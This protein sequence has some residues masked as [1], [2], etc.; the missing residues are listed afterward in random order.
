MGQQ[1]MCSWYG[2]DILHE[3]W[4]WE[5]YPFQIRYRLPESGQAGILEGNRSFQLPCEQHL[6][7]N[8][9]IQLLQCSDPWPSCFQLRSGQRQSCRDGKC[10]HKVLSGHCPW[11][12]VPSQ[13]RQH[14]GH[15]CHLKLHCST[16]WCVPTEEY[17]RRRICLQDRLHVHQRLSPRTTEKKNT[18]RKSSQLFSGEKSRRRRN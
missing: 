18:Q 9:P 16:H 12:P 4:K 2:L 11:C 6:I 5:V 17:C 3:S 1:R 10:D 13:P 7:R 8:R 15:I 14:E